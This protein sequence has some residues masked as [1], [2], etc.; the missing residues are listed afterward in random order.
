MNICTVRHWVYVVLFAPIEPDWHIAKM[1]IILLFPRNHAV[2]QTSS[3][4]NPQFT[5]I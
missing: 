4:Y 3:Q 1:Q 5:L 2:S